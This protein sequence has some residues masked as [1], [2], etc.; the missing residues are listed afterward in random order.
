M[1]LSKDD[2]ARLRQMR[3]SLKKGIPLAGIAAASLF[4]NACGE[5]AAPAIRGDI[6]PQNRCSA[7]K[8]NG[9]RENSAPAVIGEKIAG[10]P[11]SPS[12]APDTREKTKSAK[13]Y[14]VQAGDSYWRIAVLFDVDSAALEKANSVPGGKLKPGD[15]VTIPA[16]L[17]KVGYTKEAK[18]KAG[19]K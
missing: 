18:K 11:L 7:P 6:A 3:D 10:E 1:N 12:P 2:R 19:V 15:T 14:T 8:N 4:A 13:T 16:G 5:T 17:P 9:T